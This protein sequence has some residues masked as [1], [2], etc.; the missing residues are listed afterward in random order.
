[1]FGDY[2]IHALWSDTTNMD[3]LRGAATGFAGGLESM[4][5][6]CGSTGVDSTNAGGKFSCIHAPTAY[7]NNDTDN[8]ARL[9][10]ILN[11]C[12][13][14][15]RLQ[16]VLKNSTF[17]CTRRGPRAAARARATRRPDLRVATGARRVTSPR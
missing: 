6:G 11:L 10:P 7:Q 14:T 12:V 8:Q 13:A 17:R 16:C 15:V 9:T 5:I 2:A 1:M 3:N 4:P